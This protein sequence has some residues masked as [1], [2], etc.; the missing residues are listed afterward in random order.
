MSAA[1]TMTRTRSGR[2]ASVNE[3]VE[4][5]NGSGE[6]EDDSD[7][8]GA[9]VDGG[10]VPAG[11]DSNVSIMGLLSV[12]TLQ[13]DDTNEEDDYCLFPLCRMM[14]PMRKMRRFYHL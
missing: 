6:E 2:G 14:T 11:Q 5:E 9:F 4:N 13:D 10:V 3:V 7:L 12:P 1:L 8:P